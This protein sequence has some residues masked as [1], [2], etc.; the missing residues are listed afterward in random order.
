MS[1]MNINVWHLWSWEALNE[2]TVLEQNALM[3]SALGI[4]STITNFHNALA[5]YQPKNQADSYPVDEKVR[6]NKSVTANIL[7]KST[8]DPTF[9]EADR[10]SG[11]M[12][13]WIE[14]SAAWS[15]CSYG[16]HQFEL[17]QLGEEKLVMLTKIITKDDTVDTKR[18]WRNNVR[19]TMW[20]SWLSLMTREQIEVIQE[21][22]YL[23]PTWYVFLPS[24]HNSESDMVY[25][26]TINSW[27]YIDLDTNGRISYDDSQVALRCILNIS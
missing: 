8:P 3:K 14:K 16:G 20:L 21:D 25:F 13:R 4:S 27:E 17:I 5:D 12:K 23:F 2:L 10:E 19:A 9:E 22:I 6:A 11:N 18:N 26:S 24:S 15:K 7:S 1:W